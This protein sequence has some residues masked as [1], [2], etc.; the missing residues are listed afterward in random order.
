MKIDYQSMDEWS[1]SRLLIELDCNGKFYLSICMFVCSCEANCLFSNQPNI[2]VI[3]HLFSTQQSKLLLVAH[4][5]SIDQSVSPKLFAIAFHS[6]RFAT[7]TDHKSRQTIYPNAQSCGRPS[8][9]WLLGW[10]KVEHNNNTHSLNHSDQW[11]MDWAKEDI[12]TDILL[13]HCIIGMEFFEA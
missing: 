1:R 10:L 13:F 8:S 6:L 12:L 9:C 7:S 11:W 3:L 5:L 2:T 4:Q